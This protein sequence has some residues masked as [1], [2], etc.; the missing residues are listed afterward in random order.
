MRCMPLEVGC[1]EDVDAV[2]VLGGLDEALGHRLL[3]AAE[4]HARVV[5][6]LVG[7]VLAL[8]VADLRLEVVAVVRLVFADAVP[9]RPLRVSVDVHL[10]GASL[11]GVADVVAR[12]ARAAVEDEEARLVV[13]VVELLRDELLRVVQDDRLQVNVAGV[14]AVHV[15]EG[16][17]DRE[18]AVGHGRECLVDLPDL[19]GLGV[20]ARRV[21]VRVVDT[22]LLAAG[23]AELHLKEEVDLGHAL[24]VLDAGADVLLEGVLGEVEHVRGEEGLAVLLVVV[25]VSLNQAVE[26][27]QPR[28]H[29]VVRVE[30]DRDAVELGDLTHVEGTR[31][32]AGNAGGII[33]VV[34]TLA[35][36]ELATAA[37]EL[38][39]HGAT[40][41]LGGLEAARDGA[42]GDNIDGRDGVAVLLRVLQ[43][44][45]QRLAG[46]DARL[47]RGRQRRS[48]LRL[49]GRNAGTGVHLEAEG[50]DSDR[51][52]HGEKQ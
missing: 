21:D 46:N 19:L 13:A 10:D 16:G 34:G 20:E 27:R 14:H 2:E 50:R 17:G 41:L 24:E 31:D 44:V 5:V 26:P 32:G 29:A 47:D 8:G 1:L 51:G 12:R 36:V 7:L 28:A 6:L 15:A 30:D 40:V 39:D 18:H 42:R 3:A 49:H 33:S 52:Q 45:H 9:E 11:D 22:V 37:R 43:Q 35:S 38:D 48:R 25:L 4:G 23:H